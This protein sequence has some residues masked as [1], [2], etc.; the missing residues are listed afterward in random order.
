VGLNT[1]QCRVWLKCNDAQALQIALIEN[2]ERE[3]LNYTELAQSISRFV[4]EFDYTDETD[5]TNIN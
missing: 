3:D 1:V 2:L 5:A 4:H